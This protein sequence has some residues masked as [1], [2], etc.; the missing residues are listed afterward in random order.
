MSK[1]RAKGFTIVE[2]L[3]VIVVIGILAAITIVAFNGVQARAQIAKSQSDLKSMQ[4]LIELYKVDNGSYPTTVDGSGNR[5]W[6]FRSGNGNNF[7]P[8]VVPRYTANLPTPSVGTYIYM[9]DGLEYKVMRFSEIPSTEWSQ[10]PAAMKDGTGIT[11]S[12]RYGYWTSGAA[13]Y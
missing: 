4:K 13:G 3:I 8:G 1:L 10:V 12:D 6:F 7:I 2:L 11:Y 5:Q 9:S